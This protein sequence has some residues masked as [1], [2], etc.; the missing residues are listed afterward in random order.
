MACGRWADC[1]HTHTLTCIWSATA[2]TVLCTVGVL[3]YR[4]VQSHNEFKLFPAEHTL[5]SALPLLA[6]RTEEYSVFAVVAHFEAR[7]SFSHNMNRLCLNLLVVAL[8]KWTGCLSHA[9]PKLNCPLVLLLVGAVHCQSSI[10]IDIEP[11]TNASTVT[12]SV[13][14]NDNVNGT[15]TV[16]YQSTQFPIWNGTTESQPPTTN[17]TTT[18]TSRTTMTTSHRPTTTTMTSRTT[19]TTSTTTMKPTTSNGTT[20]HTTTQR[21]TTSTVPVPTLP[22]E[23]VAPSTPWNLTYG[24]KGNHCLMV[25]F[26]GRIEIMYRNVLN[27]TVTTGLD[28]PKN[29]SVSSKSHCAEDQDEETL[30]LD[31][32]SPSVPQGALMFTFLKNS[33]NKNDST[34]SGIELSLR[35]NDDL[36]PGLSSEFLGRTALLVHLAI[37]NLLNLTGEMMSLSADNL[38]LFETT[39]QHSY[40]CESLLK[41]SLVTVK[42]NGSED[43]S[44]GG[45]KSKSPFLSGTFESNNLK[46]QT[47]LPTDKDTSN[48]LPSK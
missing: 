36:F 21:P 11:G 14:T 4:T 17:H 15:S 45:S 37:S 31:I 25:T 23:P 30:I 5:P 33:T 40:S 46:V 28:V 7:S 27:H 39:V 12:P 26:A 16:S 48:F 22:P 9:N 42:V 8:R 6:V 20:H 3:H 18:T 1:K 44:E 34:L 13:V 24:A 41:T 2:S 47:F 38:S 32:E 35:I 19:T 10:D 29:A 43:M